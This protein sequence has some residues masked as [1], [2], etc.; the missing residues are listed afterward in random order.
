[1]APSETDPRLLQLPAILLCHYSRLS[2]ASPP[3]SPCHSR[4][5]S[6]LHPPGASPSPNPP[7]TPAAPALPWLTLAAVGAAVAPTL[8][9][10]LAG[11][12]TCR[13]PDRLSRPLNE[14]V[15]SSSS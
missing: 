3:A 9:P 5:R 6:M 15:R 4:A 13:R 11:C 1:M 10:P 8:A 2:H 12:S 7:H 14:A